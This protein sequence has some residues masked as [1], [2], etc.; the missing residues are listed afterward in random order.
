MMSDLGVNTIRLGVDVEV[1]CVPT[2][3]WRSNCYVVADATTRQAVLID[4]G[5]EPDRLIAA[6]VGYRVIHV[7]ATHGHYDHIGAASELCS[8][9]TL[10]LSLHYRDDALARL[11][12]IYARRFD[13]IKATVPARAP[14]HEDIT[15]SFG[16]H[17]LKVL[18]TPGHTPGSCCLVIADAIFT[19]DTLMR[20]RWGRSDLPGGDANAVASSVERVLSIANESTMLLPGHGPPWTVRAARTWL[21]QQQS[22]S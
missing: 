12:P 11:C 14:F 15:L 4:P 18:S 7:V 13:G 8:H 19:G 9:N 17:R 20:E 6:C 2:G 1:R 10:P 22:Q 5:A 16:I 3:R 21:H